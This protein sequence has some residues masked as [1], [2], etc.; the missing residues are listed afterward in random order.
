MGQRMREV[1]PFPITLV[2]GYANGYAGYLMDD[3]AHTLGTYEALASPF[4]P[5]AATTVEAGAIALLHRL[6]TM[7]QGGK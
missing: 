2:I 3:A 4:G 7:N 5:R 6:A 1:S